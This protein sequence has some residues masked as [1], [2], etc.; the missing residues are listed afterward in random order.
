MLLLADYVIILIYLKR[1]RAD[2]MKNATEQ[3]EK[4]K[5]LPLVFK[6]TVPAVVAQLIT[7]LYNIIDRV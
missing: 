1:K 5:I 3:L 2:F 7:F 4:G 6:L